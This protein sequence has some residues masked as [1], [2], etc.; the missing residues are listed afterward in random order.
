MSKWIR[1]GVFPGV[2]LLAVSAAGCGDFVRQGTSPSLVTVAALEASSG[3]E[4][5]TFGHTLQS[6]VVTNV[7][8][9]IAGN[10]VLVPT[11]FS[12]PG[13]VT[14]SV[15]MKNT[16]PSA[17][18]P[19]TANS[20]TFNRYRVTYKRA[21]GRNVP[22]VDVP[23]SFDSAVTFTAI[24]GQVITAGFDLVRHV[25]KLE[26]P[27][28]SLV[29]NDELLTMIA[30]VTFYGQ[31]HAGHDVTASGNIGITFGNFGDPD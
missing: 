27:L 8:K 4:P 11:I 18:A 13:R 17:T 7:K 24:P 23:A 12:D 16:S 14:V 1:R 21:D 2:A 15:T 25:A 28:V 20:V 9:T 19:T 29:Q 3:A 5:G 31:D 26:A 22:G 30:E 6:D 10:E